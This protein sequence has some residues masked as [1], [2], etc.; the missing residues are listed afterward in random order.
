MNDYFILVAVLALG[1]VLQLLGFWVGEII[2][3]KYGKKRQRQYRFW[4]IGLVLFVLVI[5][6]FLF[7]DVINT[8]Q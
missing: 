1:A 2:L 8:I 4:S 6:P 5:L 7:L 3:Q